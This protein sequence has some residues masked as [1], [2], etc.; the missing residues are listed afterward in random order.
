MPCPIPMGCRSFCG[1]CCSCGMKWFL[2]IHHP[3]LLILMEECCCGCGCCGA[4]CWRNSP[5]RGF[6][7]FNCC[8]HSGLVSLYFLYF[9]WIVAQLW[10]IAVQLQKCVKEEEACHLMRGRSAC[11]VFERMKNLLR[12]FSCITQIVSPTLTLD[13]SAQ[14]SMP[15]NS[16][17]LLKQVLVFLVGRTMITF[18]R[19]FSSEIVS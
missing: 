10:I 14:E 7:Q 5:T 15:E 13:N 6:V 8:Q 18:C 9:H 3:N 2:S 12:L 11:F 1:S 17:T 4:C 16:R 19:I